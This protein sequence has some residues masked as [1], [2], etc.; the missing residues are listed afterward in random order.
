MP[1]QFSVDYDT[2][3][4]SPADVDIERCPVRKATGE[5]TYILGAFNPGLTRLPSGN[6][7]MMVRVAEALRHPVVNDRI[8]S[9]R[10][11]P[12]ENYV[13]DS[14]SLDDVERVDPRLFRIL[15]YDV[16]VYRLTS[17]SWLL[18]VELDAS[19]RE[20]VKVHYDKIIE[21]R[22]SSQE[23]GIEDPRIMII[24][25]KY[26]MTVC[27]VG[28]E[29]HS[30]SLYVSDNG[31]EY[32][33]LGMILDHQN[34]DMVIFP[35]RIQGK[36]YAL[37]RP[38]GSLYFDTRAETNVRAGPSINMAESPDLLHWKPV[39]HPFLRPMEGTPMSAKVGGGAPPVRTDKGWL[40]LFHG[41]EAHD[42]VGIYRTLHAFLDH[43]EPWRIAE[44]DAESAVLEARPDL[45][46]DLEAH[47]YVRNIVF[48]SGAVVHNGSLVLA[49]GE[50]DLCCRITVMPLKQFLV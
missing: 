32:E 47:K 21:P 37:T 5:E 36:Y 48:T 45:T 50:D 12:E 41:V 14:Y 40:M 28:S 33:F 46:E 2:I 4:F 24:D 10:W 43:D 29:R 20:V 11:D 49:S 42:V 18:P 17:L 19:G 39:D 6:L 27:S 1:K 8:G 44:M 31:L 9:I 25:G 38:L 23:Y 35:E 15:A 30:T 22:S 3:I 13:I 7:L 34:K 26:Y 16:P